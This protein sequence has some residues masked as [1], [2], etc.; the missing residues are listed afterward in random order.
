M[1][2]GM[3]DSVEQNGLSW[4]EEGLDLL[5]VWEL[6]PDVSLITSLAKQHLETQA[7]GGKVTVTYLTSGSFN[8]IYDVRLEDEEFARYVFRVALPVDP[9]YKTESEIATLH[10]VKTQTTIP[11]ASVVAYDSSTKN[12]IGF[13]WILME[14]LPGARLVDCW[15]R[16]SFEA[17]ES[18]TKDLA[19]MVM[20][21]QTC[22]FDRIGSLYY[23]PSTEVASNEDELS[24]TIQAP[25]TSGADIAPQTRRGEYVVGRLV[26]RNFFRGKRVFLEVD[27]GPYESCQSFI[28]AS[29]DMEIS[30]L[31]HLSDPS[32]RED[33]TALDETIKE[34]LEFS[35][36]REEDTSGNVSRAIDMCRQLREQAHKTFGHGTTHS[37]ELLSPEQEEIQPDVCN[38]D[39]PYVLMHVDLSAKNTLVDPETFKI[40]GIIDWEFAAT[41]PLW[42]AVVYPYCIDDQECELEDLQGCDEDMLKERTEY[43][44]LTQLRK[45]Y[46]RAFLRAGIPTPESMNR[47]LECRRMRQF[48]D[49]LSDVEEN[50]HKPLEHFLSNSDEYWVT[51]ERFD[52]GLYVSSWPEEGAS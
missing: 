10:F 6:E 44:E 14:K 29:V 52:T 13:E 1:A 27:R 43:Y 20:S 37:K 26:E 23:G 9:I 11:V 7:K 38:T 5:P 42:K 36:D 32:I 39:K 19:G 51:R 4:E 18:L 12:S 41:Q 49:A 15:S 24:T 33:L 8:K 47:S 22:R 25:V 46:N 45:L 30:N 16:M 31:V 3:R 50:G 17:K 28:E 34:N 21:L 48:L 35:F 40:T 2:S